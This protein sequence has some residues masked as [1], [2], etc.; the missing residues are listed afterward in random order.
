MEERVAITAGPIE[1]EGVFTSPPD[2]AA[3]G[4]L[5]ICHPHPQYGGDMNN[6]VVAAIRDGAQ[7]AGYASLRFNFRGVGA[8]QGSHEGGRGE[9]DDV[10]AAASMLREKLGSDESEI[11]IAGYSFGAFVGSQYAAEDSGVDTCILISP[12]LEHLDFDS[13]KTAAVN[14]LFISG[15]SDPFCALPSLEGFQKGMTAQSSHLVITGADHFFF[16]QDH[17]IVAHVAQFLKQRN[18]ADG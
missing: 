13:L 11:I 2:P 9:I 6:N 15:D 8:S 1:L 4:G 17:M 16:G 14:V 5:V 10:K 7:D 18:K 3:G 12:P